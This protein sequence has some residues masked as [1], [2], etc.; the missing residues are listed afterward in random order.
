MAQRGRTIRDIGRGEGS[1]S[2]EGVD[3][4]LLE[5]VC[6]RIDLQNANRKLVQQEQ[7]I[8]W[9]LSEIQAVSCT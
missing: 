4:N 8:K 3:L 9:L 5:I 7:V 1:F 6:L 2:L